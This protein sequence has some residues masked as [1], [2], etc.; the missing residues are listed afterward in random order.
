[1]QEHGQNTTKYCVNT[2]SL[3]LEQSHIT[4]HS[5]FYKFMLIITT[6]FT[7]PRIKINLLKLLFTFNI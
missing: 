7:A 3:G 6:L 5:K 1:M 2:S 4:I